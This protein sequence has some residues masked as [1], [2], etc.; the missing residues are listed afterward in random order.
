MGTPIILCYPYRLGDN[1]RNANITLLKPKFFFFFFWGGGGWGGS[2]KESAQLSYPVTRQVLY[3]T[4]LPCNCWV[5]L[6]E[7]NKLIILSLYFHFLSCFF[8]FLIAW[9]DSFIFLNYNY[10]ELYKLQLQ[11]ELSQWKISSFMV[12]HY[13]YFPDIFRGRLYTFKFGKKK[14]GYLFIS[15]TQREHKELFST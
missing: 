13:R 4:E 6:A 7:P 3:L 9:I 5:F 1:L 10:V 12:S 14:G 15:T 11:L 2:M 8:F